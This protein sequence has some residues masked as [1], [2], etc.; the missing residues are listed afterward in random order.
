MFFNKGI[1][2]VWHLNQHKLVN[3]GDESALATHIS[4][5]KIHTNLTLKRTD[6]VKIQKKTRNL[7]LNQH[8]CKNCWYECAYD[9]TPLQYR[10]P[11]SWKERKPQHVKTMHNKLS[12]NINHNNTM[13]TS[14]GCQYDQLRQCLKYICKHTV[15]NFTLYNDIRC[16]LN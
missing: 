1:N 9:C 14:A 5:E 11:H 13:Q 3:F 15:T 2:R 7:N 16:I 4:R 8:T 12:N 10:I 6:K